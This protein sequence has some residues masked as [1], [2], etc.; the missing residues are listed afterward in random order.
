MILTLILDNQLENAKTA[1]SILSEFH[2]RYQYTP[3]DN[4][5]QSLLHGHTFQKNPNKVYIFCLTDNF[6]FTISLTAL[7]LQNLRLQKLQYNN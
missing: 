5:T 2:L 3:N 6:I 1:K 7:S 4:L